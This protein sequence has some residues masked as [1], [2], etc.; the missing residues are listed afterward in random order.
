[1]SERDI[2]WQAKE[3]KMVALSPQSDEP[4]QT[5][6][7]SPLSLFPTTPKVPCNDLFTLIADFFDWLEMDWQ[8]PL[9]AK[10]RPREPL[11]HPLDLHV[12]LYTVPDLVELYGRSVHTVHQFLWKHR[13]PSAG[14][15]PTG[16]GGGHY[17][18]YHKQDLLPVIE[19]WEWERL[20]NAVDIWWLRFFPVACGTC[21]RCR[22]HAHQVVTQQ[23]HCSGSVPLAHLRSV[24]HRL[25]RE[26]RR[27]GSIRDWWQTHAADDWQGELCGDWGIILIYLLDRRLLHLSYDEL[28]H[29]KPL[30]DKTY[31][32]LA[33]LWRHRHPD[34]YEQFQHALEMTRYHALAKDQALAVLSLLVFLKHGSPSLADL[35]RPLLPEELEQVCCEKRLV[36]T[37]LGWGA[38]LP[39]PLHADVRVGH[40]ALDDIRHYFW[41]YA[42]TQPQPQSLYKGCWDKGPRHFRQGIIGTI[43][44]AL[45]APAY[46]GKKGILSRRPETERKI[47]SPYRIVYEGKMNNAGYQL[48]PPEV[49]K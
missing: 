35:E 21:Q 6:P 22:S 47:I 25:L 10:A 43:E 30:R 31:Q 44:Q 34:E 11:P 27:L 14:T 40:V 48:L 41:Q 46:D 4:L 15:R 36:T 7:P 45:A 37:H 42:A 26:V 29:L 2:F 23:I 38:F 18:L 13:I 12:G 5:S 16:K 17:T 39:Y 28:I 49:Q 24:F 33:R 20:I 8:L 32:D 3:N 1:M 9:L 19:Q